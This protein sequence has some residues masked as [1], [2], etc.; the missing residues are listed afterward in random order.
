MGQDWG[1]PIGMSVAS[2][3]ADRVQG[4]VMGNT[5][6]WPQIGWTMSSFSLVMSSYPLQWLIKQRNFLV[7][8]LMKRS[9]VQLSEAE[10]DH[11]VKVV[12]SPA[13]R[14]GIAEF[15]HQIR[16]ARPWLGEVQPRV[17]ATLTEKPVLLTW[18]MRNFAFRRSPFLRRWQETFPQATTLHLEQAGH[19]IQEDAPEAIAEAIRAKF[20][21]GA[22]GSR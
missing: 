7:S 15:P 3:R 20:I 5:W 9:L 10:F 13:S 6:F 21:D 18:G 16:A 14:A 4:L 2:E 19:F 12:P 22:V 1:G 17:E 8:P 11:Y